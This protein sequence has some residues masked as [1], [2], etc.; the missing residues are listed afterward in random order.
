MLAE[1][2][3]SARENGTIPC[4]SG[5]DAFL[6]YDTFGFPVEITTEV[7]EERGVSIDM[8]GFD[9]EMENQ[10][11]Q[12]QAAHNVVKLAVENDSDLAEKIPDIEFL[13]YNTTMVL[14]CLEKN[15]E[16]W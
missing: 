5:K 2:L 11:R 13:G 8:N 9:I 7:A 3:L 16:N 1:A 15:M 6:L 10:W 12:S 14:Q 4:L